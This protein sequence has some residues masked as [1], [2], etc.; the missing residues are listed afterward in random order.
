MREIL[1]R[2]DA[3]LAA[4][5]VEPGTVDRTAPAAGQHP[6]PIEGI[7]GPMSSDPLRKAQKGT[8]RVG[9]PMY[10]PNWNP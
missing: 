6:Y 1:S 8:G 5:E 10:L 3:L 9:T 4:G 2:I 7:L